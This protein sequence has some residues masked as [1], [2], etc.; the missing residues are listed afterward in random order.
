MTQIRLLL[1][2]LVG[3]LAVVVLAP[4]PAFACSCVQA[5]LAEHVDDADV[6]V[7]ATVDGVD[8]PGLL[9]FSA[10]QAR[11]A[12]TVE[13]ALKGEVSVRTEVHSA[14][15]GA[16]CGLEGVEE[17]GR[18]VVFAHREASGTLSASLCGG[19][20]PVTSEVLA[21]TTAAAGGAGELFDA[22]PYESTLTMTFDEPLAAGLA[23]P[24]A[25]LAGAA[26]LLITGGLWL[27]L[28]RS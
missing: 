8:R 19:T 15:S 7:V 26:L 23:A 22:S 4:G 18:Y 16:S 24:L 27:R 25:V 28:V 17:G 13:Q 21:E 9:A 12:L 14:V 2:A 10:D 1:A 3:A 5:S 11:Y 20:R 6:V